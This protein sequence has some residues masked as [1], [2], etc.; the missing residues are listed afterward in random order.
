ME[1]KK[2]KPNVMKRIR[3]YAASHRMLITLGRVLAAVSALAAMVPFYD[4]WRIIKIA[5][6]GEN[7]GQIKYLGWQAVGITLLGM[8]L[9]ICA[10]MC[11]HI[12]A[13]R[14]QANM[15]SSLMRHIMAMPMGV[16]DKEGT[17]KIRRIVTDST[18]ATESYIAH[19]LPDKTVAAV[20][21][22]GLV[23]MM[24]IFDWRMGLLCMIPA[25]IGFAFMMAMM[26]EK[27]KT[28]MQEYQNALDAMSNEAVE[29]VRGV[30]VVKTFGQTVHS[31]RRFKHTIDAYEK[32]TIAYTRN[33][34]PA[35]VA[36]M[37]AINAV[38]AALI[39]AVYLLGHHGITPD[40][41][42]NAMYYI[43][44]TPV[45]TVTLTKIA[46]AGEQE[47]TLLDAMERVESVLAMKP[48]DDAADTA[49]GADAGSSRVR[50]SSV[51]LDHV[52]FRY[53]GAERN[54]LSDLSL[55]IRAGS[56]AALVGPSGGGKS[57][58]AQL[59][60]RFFDVTE[61]SIRIG[62]V[63][64]R[65]IPQDALAE[66]VSFVFQ[67]S[68]LLNTSILE[69]VRLA[70]PD[71]TEAEV[72]EALEKAQCMDIIEK[73]PQGIETVLGTKG[74]YLSGGEQQRISIARAILK[75]AP[76]LIL[77]EATAFADPDHEAKVQEAF[78]AMSGDKTVIMIAHRLSTVMDADDIFVLDEGRVREHGTH[79]ELLSQGGLYQEMYEEF[80][81]S[82]QWKVGA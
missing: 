29:Y 16:F 50:D 39:A 51:V 34:R 9:Y 35:M 65:K 66:L 12:A 54:A 23:A 43:L 68:R 71:A 53:E 38:F 40:L 52:S 15:R 48:L 70:R 79:E 1:E 6:S 5:V 64:V 61:G 20:T 59:I 42:S 72:L 37:T 49:A 63:D 26:G 80:H 76:I 10:L 24:L 67:D 78:T 74:T 2:Q 11:T 36:F 56:K 33:M 8:F 21:P 4:L 44:I 14:V 13:F 45:L 57:T 19:S 27:M 41:I 69:N 7:L 17:G 22:A 30:P 75:D 81:R 18:A 60:A 46:Y 31:F 47:M 58:T 3:P 73:L 25:I 77:D 62:G 55:T 28:S 82:I 32:W